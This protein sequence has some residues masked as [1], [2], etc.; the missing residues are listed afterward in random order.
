MQALVDIAGRHGLPLSPGFII[1][2]FELAAINA[3]RR[4]FQASVLHGCFFHLSQNV[5]RRV[6][7]TG[8]QTLY[9]NDATFA[10]S[11]RQLCALSFLPSHRIRRVRTHY[12]FI[13]SF[14]L[15]VKIL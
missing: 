14:V 2:D 4:V 12:R 6:Q 11:V 13:S 3:L 1:T 9:V 15:L 10:S 8:I 5:F 7:K